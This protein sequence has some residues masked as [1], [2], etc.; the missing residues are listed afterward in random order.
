MTNSYKQTFFE[1]LRWKLFGET[2]FI[3]TFGIAFT[4]IWFAILFGA[5]YVIHHFIQKYW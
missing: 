2:N 4:A 5:V 1:K 3:Y